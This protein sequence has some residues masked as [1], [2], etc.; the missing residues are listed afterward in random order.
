MLQSAEKQNDML[1]KGLRLCIKH[2]LTDRSK[3]FMLLKE[4][5]VSVT[6]S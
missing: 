2:L 4:V 1:Q 5:T 3:L 6:L